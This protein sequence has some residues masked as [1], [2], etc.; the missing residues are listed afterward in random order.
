[1]TDTPSHICNEGICVVCG[2]T[3][4]RNGGASTGNTPSREARMADDEFDKQEDA[5]YFDG[6]AIARL[7][8]IAEARRA[9]DQEITVGAALLTVSNGRDQLRAD[10]A[11]EKERADATLV[12]WKEQIEADGNAIDDLIR[13]R[14]ALRAEVERLKRERCSCG[15]LRIEC[16]GH[17][18]AARA[19]SERLRVAREALSA[20]AAAHWP[21]CE[22]VEFGKGEC[23]CAKKPAA[24]ALERTKP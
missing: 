12:R 9:R 15:M 7:R 2:R 19:A 20:I 23:D 16:K 5:F 10:L 8:L 14:D 24:S 13:E 22:I 17:Q 11:R 18:D 21:G 1:M 4:F 3:V 6:N